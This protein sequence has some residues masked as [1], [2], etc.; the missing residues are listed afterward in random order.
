MTTEPQIEISA[1]KILTLEWAIRSNSIAP[2]AR[3]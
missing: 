2:D 3:F 1:C